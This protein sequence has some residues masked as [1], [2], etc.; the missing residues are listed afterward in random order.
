MVPQFYNQHHLQIEEKLSVT[1]ITDLERFAE[2]SCNDQGVKT[3][4]TWKCRICGVVSSQRINFKKHLMIHSGEKPYS[5]SFCGY[6]TAR[7]ENLKR[8][9]NCRHPPSHFSSTLLEYQ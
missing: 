3:W 4:N 9:V 2:I 7:K 8:H 5:C 1:T 6:K